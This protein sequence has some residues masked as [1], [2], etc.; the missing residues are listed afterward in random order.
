[1]QKK[2]Y[3]IHKLGVVLFFIMQILALT[4]YS[5]KAR[6]IGVISLPVLFI[7]LYGYKKIKYQN[8][9]FDRNFDKVTMTMAILVLAIIFY[10]RVIM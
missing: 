5:S 10:Q 6:L 7:L 8:S 9:S 2:L 3:M 4:Y 1:M